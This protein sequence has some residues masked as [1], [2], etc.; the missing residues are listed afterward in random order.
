[1]IAWTIAGVLAVGAGVAYSKR[2]D[3]ADPIEQQLA[4]QSPLTT[5]VKFDS[6]PEKT[7]F[8]KGDTSVKLQDVQPIPERELRRIR[9]SIA[10]RLRDSIARAERRRQDSIAA[11]ERSIREPVRGSLPP[12]EMS[13]PLTKREPS[14]AD[15]TSSWVRLGTRQ[16]QTIIYV[17]DE[18]RGEL[19]RVQWVRVPA[20]TVRLS[21]RAPNCQPWDT[22]F[23]APAGDSVTLGIRMPR[24]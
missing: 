5:P 1:M 9:D 16:Y 3:N 17:N 4:V 10:N 7:V 14:A 6:T 15:A 2:P 22:T 11:N 20:G 24:C 18:A 23:A 8:V 21:L 12:P 19:Y 13:T